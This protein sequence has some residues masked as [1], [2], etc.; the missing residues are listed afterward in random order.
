MGASVLESFD[1]IEHAK[2]VAERFGIAINRLADRED[3][4]E[5]RVWLE[6]GRKRITDAL[7]AMGDLFDRILFLPE[8][9]PLRGDVA[10][11]KQDEACDAVDGLLAAITKL[12]ERSPLIEVLFRN[13]KPSVAMRR[14]KNEAFETYCSELEKRQLST[15]AARMLADDTYAEIIPAREKLA[16]AFEAWRESLKP[17]PLA[18]EVEEALR[19]ELEEASRITFSVKQALLLAE[20]ALLAEP[21]VREES[22][23]FEKPRKR[24]RLRDVA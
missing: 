10:R 16:A 14:A 19:R 9:K 12:N 5:E 1:E 17:S 4:L 21:A 2:V 7:E 23:L 15:Y 24:A 6:A 18:P 22:A 20:A 8:L 13:V 3:R 11:Q